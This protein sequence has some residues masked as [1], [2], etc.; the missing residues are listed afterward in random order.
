MLRFKEKNNRNGVAIIIVLGMMALLMMLGVAFS[1][2]MRIERRSAGNYSHSV[3]TKNLVWAGL[4]RAID[5]IENNPTYGMLNADGSVKHVFPPFDALSSEDP[6]ASNPIYVNLGRGEALDYIPGALKN[7]AEGAESEWV[8]FSVEWGSGNNKATNVPGLFSYLILN[9]SDF[10]DANYAGGATNRMAGVDASE[11]QLVDADFTQND[12]DNFVDVRD[13]D[14]RYETLQEQRALTGITNDKFVVFSRYPTNGGLISL[15]GSVAELTTVVRSEKIKDELDVADIYKADADF[16]FNSMIDYIDK[17]S[18]PFALDEAYV[19]R[20]PMINEVSLGRFRIDR[21]P[22]SATLRERDITIELAYPFVEKSEENFKLVGSVTTII[23]NTSANVTFSFD[24]PIDESIDIT[25]EYNLVEVELPE[26]LNILVPSTNN[27]DISFEVKCQVILDGGDNNGVVVDAQ[28]G[29]GLV[30]GVYHAGV[31]DPFKMAKEAIPSLECV[32][33]RFNWMS[34]P[35]G[36]GSVADIKDNAG[37]QWHQCV[38]APDTDTEGDI[39][40]ATETWFA[41]YPREDGYDTN[42]QMRVSNRGSLASVGELGNLI[43]RSHRK[44]KFNTIRLYDYG[45]GSSAVRDKVFE[46]FTVETNSVRRGL[47]NINSAFPEMIEPAFVDAPIGYPESS[48]K[49]TEAMAVDIAN[50]ITNAG[51]YAK[52]PEICRLAW[53]AIPGLEDLTDLEVESIIS[54]SYGLF[55]I[56][57]NLFAIIVSASPVTTS[58][59]EF[60]RQTKQ[61]TALGS[62]RAI[63]YVWR[64]PFADNGKHKCF[65]QFFKWL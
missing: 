22:A 48:T 28:A 7:M 24:D 10:I 21:D 9:C 49:V 2:S 14:I 25:K 55:G 50:S 62:K 15:A 56:R 41:E 5:D 35:V 26:R 3:A 16:I 30:F 38:N 60:A 23:S 34:D 54:H 57:Q 18:V 45:V 42:M 31:D 8:N 12:L 1:V 43:R 27:I 4:A 20:V 46:N 59:G 37:Y 52:T 58:M 36:D 11:L 40:K 33:P 6:G 64:D 63:A 17:D 39:N 19:E 65:V 51:A 44:S 47:V 61:I 53:K 13:D 29:I 32:D